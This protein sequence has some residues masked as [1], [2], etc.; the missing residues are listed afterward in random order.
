MTE[1][2]EEE[3]RK[4]LRSAAQ[5]RPRVEPAPKSTG[6]AYL[7]PYACVSCRKSFKR[8]VE[9][10]EPGL[11]DKQCP[12]CGGVAT[13]LYRHFKAP[14]TNDILQWKKVALL[15]QNGF[16]FEHLRD[17]NGCAVPYPSTM[18]EAREFVLRYAKPKQPKR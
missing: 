8:K 15:I 11:P 16:R 3:F 6:P 9:E 1:L 12:H 13:G 7:F 14:P 4:A 17:Q 5:S 2:S 10:H 18:A